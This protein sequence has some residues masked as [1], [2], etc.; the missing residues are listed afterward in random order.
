M[1]RCLIGPV[2]PAFASNTLSPS[3]DYL[4]FDTAGKLDR[5]IAPGETWD[6]LLRRLPE[7]WKPD[8]LVLWLYYTTIPSALWNAPVPIIGLAPDWNLL[9]HGYRRILKY[10]DCVYTD[11]QGV[12]VLQSE[13]IAHVRQGNLFGL[14]KTFVEEPW[15]ERE[16]TLMFFSWATSTRMCNG[17]AAV[18][19]VA[20]L[21]L[22]RAGKSSSAPACAARTA[23]SF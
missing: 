15:P 13:G 6:D 18:G 10:C 11:K 4:F 8:F 9:W 17:N 19:S 14:D 2:T 12:R 5:T 20:W 16:A 1:P 7:G 3:V 21:N 23:G 22:D